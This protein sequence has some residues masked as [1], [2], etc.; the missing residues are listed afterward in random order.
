[1]SEPTPSL[2]TPEPTKRLPR[3]ARGYFVLQALGWAVPLVIASLVIGAELARDGDVADWI[4]V[5]VI[6]LGPVIAAV[7]GIVV[8]LV[9]WSRWRY[10]LRDEEL[11]LQRGAWVVTRT[12]IP[13]LRVQHVDTRRSWLADQLS[14]QAVI[15][16]TA[17][18]SHEI[19]ALAPGEAASIR[20]RI[21]LLAR[22]P[23]EP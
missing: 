3:A 21:A 19:P 15:V 12:L 16:H 14:L 5:V 1:M 17:A 9:R 23:D 2:S 20:D 4:G 7:G 11:D 18:G 6:V 8:P 13:M 22:Q 10:E